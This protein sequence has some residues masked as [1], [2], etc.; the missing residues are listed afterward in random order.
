LV[1]S[2]KTTL[3]L[4]SGINILVG[5]VTVR[6]GTATVSCDSVWWDTRS[7]RFTAH[8]QV[9]YRKGKGQTVRS[10]NLTYDQVLAYF[11]GNVRAEQDRT[12]IQTESLS[13]LVADG[14]ARWTQGA[15]IQLTD[16]TLTCRTGV[17]N[18]KSGVH[19]FE[20]SVVLLQKDGELRSEWVE[21]DERTQW[22]W[23]RS[24]GELKR[25]STQLTFSAGRWNSKQEEGLFWG[26]AVAR[27]PHSTVSGDT[28]MIQ[29]EGWS[30]RG[31]AHLFNWQRNDT[32]GPILDAGFSS[33]RGFHGLQTKGLHPIIPS[34]NQATRRFYRSLPNP[35]RYPLHGL[36]QRSVRQFVHGRKSINFRLERLQPSGSNGG[37]AGPRFLCFHR[38][39]TGNPTP[40]CP[41]Q[42]PHLG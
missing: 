22:A 8:G 27:Q 15:K 42:V 21:Y 20:K 2:Q 16:G 28:L 29:E 11:T 7:Q 39:G 37:K 14:T 25:D 1:R 10:R 35:E 18:S 24:A 6:Q 30:S 32:P 3:G 40:K 36:A 31:R 41:S 13:V 33:L 9:V 23:I 17:L 34:S 5:Q 19:R 4:A 38:F 12:I 26:S